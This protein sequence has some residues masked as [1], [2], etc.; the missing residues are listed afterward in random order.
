MLF[1]DQ[2][3]RI[4]DQLSSLGGEILEVS[5]GEPLMHPRL[6]QI[7]KYAEESNLETVLYTSGNVLDSQGKIASLGTAVAEK[8]RR[9]SLQRIVFNLQGAFP[10]THETIT[11]VEGSFDNAVK[12]IRI[13]KSL[14][15][16][17]GV[18]FVPM[19]PN[20]KEFKSL[21]QLC[22]KLEVD[23]IG[24]L[25]FVPQ[26]RGQINR[27]L[28]ELST[29]EFKEFNM[30]LSRSTFEYGNINI[31]VGRPIDFRNLFDSSFVKPLC[32]AGISRC[33]ITPSG[34]VVPCPA[35]KQESRYVAGNLSK[36]SLVDIW[37]ES[38]VWQQFRYF[39][40]TRLG[41]PCRGCQHLQQCRGGC[42]AQRILK[43]KD[44][45]AAPDPSCFKCA[46]S[47]AA[48]CSSNIEVRQRL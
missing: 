48:T 28:L 43:Y 12:A 44:L 14:G 24:I 21:L 7:I 35:F 41:E 42:S 18:H 8:L 40:I 46:I 20:F 17:V 9:S 2:I 25:R 47:A 26:G 1:I 39:D 34:A 33:T 45:Y 6:T 5:G 36:D 15:F 13:V 4:L 32:D 11:R 22:H 19:K 30:A 37:N 3:K 10:R 31:R 27:V 29:E 23:E 38:S 16:W